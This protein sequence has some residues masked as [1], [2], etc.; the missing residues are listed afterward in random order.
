MVSLWQMSGKS[1]LPQYTET[2]DDSEL[3][4]FGI[5]KL[6]YSCFMEV[7]TIAIDIGGSTLKVATWNNSRDSRI[8]SSA[9]MVAND[10]RKNQSMYCP[11]LSAY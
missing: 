10:A 2:K 7:K 5:S 8:A 11:I 9:R 6:S 3:D 4:N 1:F